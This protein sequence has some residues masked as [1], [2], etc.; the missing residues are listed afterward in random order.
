MSLSYLSHL[1]LLTSPSRR[2]LSCSAFCSF[3]L[4]S[5]ICLLNSPG[6]EWKNSITMS[7]G[8][9]FLKSIGE[10]GESY[11]MK[12]HP[13]FIQTVKF[14]P[15]WRKGKSMVG[16]YKSLKLESLVWIGGATFPPTIQS[17]LNFKTVPITLKF[18]KRTNA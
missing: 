6:R 15:D 14:E 7:H 12:D 2:A 18:S 16:L 4:K 8:Y 13:S 5:F 17:S 10:K 11:H 9:K 1:L 3:I